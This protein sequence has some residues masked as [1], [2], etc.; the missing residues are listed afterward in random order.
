MSRAAQELR[1]A[2]RTF[3][4]GRFV[5]GLAIL[6]FALG[7][8]VTTAV[9]SIFNSVLLTPLPY[10]DPEEL[11]MIFD[12]QPACSTCPASLPKYHDWRERS[13]V[14]A[15][16]GGSTQASF[17]LTG[18]GSAPERVTALATTASLNDV[19]RVTPALGRWYTPDEDQPGG[20]KVVVLTHAYW[21]RRFGANPALIGQTVVFDDAAYEVIGVMPPG[22]SHRGGDAF[23]PLQR[24]VDPATLR[25][26]RHE[27]RGLMPSVIPQRTRV[28][29]S[30]GCGQ[31]SN[32]AI[33]AL[34]AIPA[35]AI[36]YR[37]SSAPDPER[38]MLRDSAAALRHSEA[39]GVLAQGERSKREIEQGDAGWS[40]PV[41]KW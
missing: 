27:F 30:A 23:V 14:L 22:F 16:L 36:V 38:H 40:R 35:S 19:F 3:V 32:L 29:R 18:S 39:H 6:A 12:T 11:V 25:D 37:E 7:I 41:G 13:Q 2:I 33:S 21:T 24:K 9:F 26:L 17:V 34:L 4:R 10:P 5:T 15:A 31:G 20:R 28:A 1:Y 8:G